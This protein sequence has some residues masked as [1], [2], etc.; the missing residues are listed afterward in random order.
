MSRKLLIFVLFAS[1]TLLSLG[2]AAA[3]DA[4][5]LTAWIGTSF[6]AAQQKQFDDYAAA[7]GV[8]IETEVF[9]NPFEQ[10]LLAKWAAG[11][12]PDIL[13]FHAIGNWIVQLN[14]AENLQDL[15]NEP[16]VERTIPGILDKSSMYQGVIYAAILNYPYIDGVFYNKQIFADL[17]LELP[18]NYED[19]LLLCETIKEQAPDISPIV[20][21]GGDQWPLQVFPFMMWNDGLIENDLIAKVNANEE[22]FTHPVFVDGVAKLKELQDN[23]CLN[24][25]LLTATF[26]NEQEALMEGTGAMVFQGSWIVGSLMESYGL[27]ALNEKIGVFGLSANSDVVSWQTVGDGA[28]YAPK[29]GD[30]ARETAA[31]DFINWATGEDYEQFL[32]DSKQ[33]PIL[34]GYDVPADVP[35]VLVEANRLFLEKSVPQY[36]Q[37][38][39]ASYGAFE[40]YLSEMVSGQSTPEDVMQK[41]DTE[42]QRSAR[43]LGL[44]GF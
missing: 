17:G 39:L 38:L 8:T 28:I 36:Q 26:V 29:T 9:P 23:G 22:Q 44:P 15:S 16:F 32:A 6:P 5:T 14:P 11:D 7:T 10:N 4:V 21:G 12:R 1:F 30:E 33:F 2:T 13:S 37:T 41:M 25:D 19:L 20:M 24:D 31:R 3:Q 18:S 42:F 34:Q 43:L 40:T 35:D 27:E